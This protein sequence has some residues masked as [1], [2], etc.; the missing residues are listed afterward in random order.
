MIRLTRHL[1]MRFIELI[2]D[3]VQG[4][5]TTAIPAPMQTLCVLRFLSQGSFQKGAASDFSNTM[6][7]SPM[8]RILARVNRAIV[9]LS[10]RFISFPNNRASR[11]EVAN[12]YTSNEFQLYNTI[13]NCVIKCL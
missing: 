7:Q 10:D 1:A 3:D 6:C 4:R 13:G 2:H 8:S 11:E 5:R 12:S 9:R